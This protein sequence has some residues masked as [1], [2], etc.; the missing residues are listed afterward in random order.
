MKRLHNKLLLLTGIVALTFVSPMN[1][2]AATLDI[3]DFNENLRI[4]PVGFSR[5]TFEI[6]LLPGIDEEV[7]GVGFYFSDNPLAPTASPEVFIYNMFEDDPKEPL[8]MRCCSDTLHIVLR[9]VA[10]PTQSENME[11]GVD[12]VSDAERLRGKE[13]GGVDA[14]EIVL[15]SMRDVNVNVFS[16]VPTPITGAGL[17][18]LILAGGGLLAW[19]RRR[20]KIA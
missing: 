12:F 15:F 10:N 1:V 5:N 20:K 8:F 13:E 14:G 7:A 2:S 18:G 19:W 9:P 6:R 4:V 3:F 16:A 17:P 11:V